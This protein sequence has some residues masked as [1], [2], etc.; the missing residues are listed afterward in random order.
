MTTPDGP[1]WIKPLEWDRVDGTCWRTSTLFGQVTAHLI[2]GSWRLNVDGKKHR[3]I[4]AFQ[5]AAK[6]WHR[7][8]ILPALELKG[9]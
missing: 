9:D 4:E 3:T 8:R 1:Y 7:E 5:L 6:S 2:H